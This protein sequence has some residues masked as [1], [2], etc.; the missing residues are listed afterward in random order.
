M[1]E[2][3]IVT[4]GTR[5]MLR[6]RRLGNTDQ[7]R[8]RERVGSVGLSLTRNTT[9]RSRGRRMADKSPLESLIEASPFGPAFAENRELREQN[10]VL[11]AALRKYGRHLPT[12]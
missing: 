2:R 9:T 1:P 3:R 6:T 10:R 11:L 7:E 5:S 4:E 12:C 8:A